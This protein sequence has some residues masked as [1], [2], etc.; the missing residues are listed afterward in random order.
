M[1]SKFFIM[2][3]SVSQPH[4]VQHHHIMHQNPTGSMHNITII[5]KQNIPH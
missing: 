1:I 3:I 2:D 5:N 4:H